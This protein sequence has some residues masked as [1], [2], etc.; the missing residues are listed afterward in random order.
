VAWKNNK[1]EGKKYPPRTFLEL[2]VTLITDL[3]RIST[4]VKY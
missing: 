2:P 3:K 4:S 1:E